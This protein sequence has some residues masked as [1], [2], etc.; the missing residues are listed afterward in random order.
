[1]SKAR[2][3]I[4]GLGYVG[5]P[6][7]LRFVERG[8][9]VYG[10]DI[11]GY[12]VGALRRGESF[13]PDI[14][15]SRIRSALESGLHV[16]ESYGPLS[17]AELVVVAV[18]T[19]LDE[20]GTKP[21]HS[22][23]TAAA[24]GLAPLL[25][26]GATVVLESTVAP[27]TTEGRFLEEFT[28]EGLTPD[29]DFYLAYSPERINPGSGSSELATIPKLV[30]GISAL[31]LGKLKIYYS[32]VFDE[33]VDVDGIKEA[34]FAKLLENSYRLVN[35]SFVNELALAASELGIDFSEVVRA[36]TTKPYGFQPF[37]PT[38]GAGGHC[39]PVD[40]V[41][42]HAE[43]EHNTANPQSILSRAIEVNRS[44][45]LRFLSE[46]VGGRKA[47][48]GRRVLV[49][50]LA[51]KE[52]VVDTRNAPSIEVIKTLVRWGASITVFDELVQKITVDGRE[53]V[54]LNLEEDSERWDVA[55][56]LH[57]LP[58]SAV[59]E[60]GRYASEVFS[61]VGY[62]GRVETTDMVEE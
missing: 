59:L 17:M 31:S 51:Y 46:V 14:P 32:D 29:K 57:K 61:G 13:S 19:P 56:L 39:I 8:Y 28:A 35:I 30:A 53:Y 62:F 1:M 34:E 26:P 4:I 45:P 42:L 50:G 58:R 20:S 36:A 12:R 43:L 54:V 25:R 2:V 52:G 24:A 55:I 27:G 49:A 5:L 21:D 23:V 18:P 37:F 22:M 3:G 44:V 11:S 15:G 41:F 40:P 7:A 9:E 6:V 60:L 10:V 47:V 38:I 48:E 33:L 16:G